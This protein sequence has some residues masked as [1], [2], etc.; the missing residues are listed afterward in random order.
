MTNHAFLDTGF[1]PNPAATSAALT[2]QAMEKRMQQNPLLQFL[3]EKAQ[4]RRRGGGKAL[5]GKV[6]A[7]LTKANSANQTARYTLVPCRMN[8][9]SPVE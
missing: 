3:R 7:I 5:A 6:T 4:S 9:L 2:A 1:H 8:T